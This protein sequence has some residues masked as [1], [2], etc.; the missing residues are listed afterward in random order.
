M[1]SASDDSFTGSAGSAL[2]PSSDSAALLFVDS[3]YWV[4]AGKQVTADWEVKRVGSRGS[5]GKDD[6]VGG[7]IDAVA[8]VSSTHH[9]GQELI[10]GPTRRLA[11]RYRPKVDRSE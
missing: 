4:Q 7:W 11:C 2:I 1:I 10:P 5:S 9:V 6:V 8:D 3:R